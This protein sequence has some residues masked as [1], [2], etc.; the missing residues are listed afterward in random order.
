MIKRLICV[1]L[2]VN[3]KTITHVDACE[4]TLLMLCHH[5]KIYVVLHLCYSLC[6]PTGTLFLFWVSNMSCISVT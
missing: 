5:F 3:L 4:K 1:N 6:S 2:Q